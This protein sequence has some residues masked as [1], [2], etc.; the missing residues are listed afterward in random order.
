MTPDWTKDGRKKDFKFQVNSVDDI[1]EFLVYEVDE[2]GWVSSKKDDFVGGGRV[3]VG[4]IFEGTKYSKATK[5]AGASQVERLFY[6]SLNLAAN[7]LSA[8][9]REKAKP[10]GELFF[11]GLYEPTL[12]PPQKLVKPATDAPASN[13]D[14]GPKN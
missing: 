5:E 7:Y 1:V 4:T 13:E 3:R 12:P 9:G 14:E 2:A 11:T 8:T 6:G 10:A